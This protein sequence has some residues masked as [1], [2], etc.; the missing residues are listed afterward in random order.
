MSYGGSYSSTFVVDQSKLVAA[1]EEYD[2]MIETY[3]TIVERCRRK[4]IPSNYHEPDLHKGEMVCID[5]CVFKFA[6]VQQ[7]LVP[8]M[9]ASFERFKN[10]GAHADEMP[11]TL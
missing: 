8:K 3:K 4:C 7:M 9:E 10:L 11:S 2:R 6:K 1:E 5:R